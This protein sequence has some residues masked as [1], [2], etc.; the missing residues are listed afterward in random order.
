MK[1]NRLM[2]ERIRRVTVLFKE[3]GYEIHEG[4]AS[5]DSYSAGFASNDG[6]QAG[7]FI[8]ADSKFLELAFTFTFGNGMAD[9]VRERIE[10]V[11]HSLY[12][13]GC[14]FS[15]Q[16]DEQDISYTIFSKI[17]FA[18]LNYFSLKETIRDFREA[19]DANQEIFE[20]QLENEQ[21]ASHGDS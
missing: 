1:P 20:I 21:G 19:I 11:M 9:F 14:Y 16:I 6:F 10:E 17:Y 12:E 4:D 7:F 13:F 15:L 5:E 18:G 8:D 3:L 2:Q